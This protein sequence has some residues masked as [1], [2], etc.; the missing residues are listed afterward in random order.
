MHLL[1]IWVICGLVGNQLQILVRVAACNKS[2][3]LYV[4]QSPLQL[5]VLIRVEM[6]SIQCYVIKYFSD[7][8][9]IGCFLRVYTVSSAYTIN[10]YG[11]DDSK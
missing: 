11:V 8:L 2:I 7:L 6:F 4:C 1:A 5:P 9:Q 10:S 3:Y